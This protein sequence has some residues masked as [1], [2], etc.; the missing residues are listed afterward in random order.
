MLVVVDASVVVQIVVAGGD[1]GPLA[2]HEM[3]AP[4][5]MRSES[6]S[7]ISELAYRG[8][9]P[10]EAARLAAL[11]LAAVPVRSDRPEGLDEQAWDLA[12]SLGWAKTYDAEYVALAMIHDIPL[13]TIDA[14]L[15][16]GVGHLVAMPRIV[17][18]A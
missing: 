4:P 14:R 2:A 18:L 1:P 6:L 17:D 16:R 5:L 7:T 12:R 3:I 10:P 13:L 9:I 8:E 11:R 15:R